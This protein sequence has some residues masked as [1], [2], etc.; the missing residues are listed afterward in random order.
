[1]RNIKKVVKSLCFTL[2][3]M[4]LGLGWGGLQLGFWM[5]SSLDNVSQVTF[6]EAFKH[7]L[8]EYEQ[9]Q[10]YQDCLC[11]PCQLSENEGQEDSSGALAL[12]NV[13]TG[14]PTPAVEIDLFFDP[15]ICWLTI[16]SPFIL[17]H[18]IYPPDSPPPQFSV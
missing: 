18:K 3:L 4:S 14:V 1:M 11:V 7:S 9:S 17:I 2:V 12:F 6:K 15:T 8:T 10:E 16:D 5:V 13:L